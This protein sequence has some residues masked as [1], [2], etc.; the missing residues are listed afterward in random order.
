M[1]LLISYFQAILDCFAKWLR[2]GSIDT[3]EIVAFPALIDICF[4]ALEIK[5]CFEAASD[6]IYDFVGAMR[7]QRQ[8]DSAMQVCFI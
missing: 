5:A 4:K 8:Q 3:K 6:V 7:R 2:F 1:I